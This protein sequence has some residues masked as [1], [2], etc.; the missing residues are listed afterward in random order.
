MACWLPL[1]IK[2]G[3]HIVTEEKESIFSL[4]SNIWW[5]MLE[6]VIKK[7]SNLLQ[8]ILFCGWENS[9]V[10]SLSYKAVR[11][12]LHR[13]VGDA[14]CWISVLPLSDGSAKLCMS[15]I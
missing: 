11:T 4:F 7:D 3:E 10:A 9:L 13:A 14:Q 2:A 5:Q 6:K 8:K 1:L 15:K 12:L